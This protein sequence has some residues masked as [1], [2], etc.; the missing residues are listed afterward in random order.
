M[1]V[2]TYTETDAAT[3]EKAVQVFALPETTNSSEFKSMYGDEITQYAETAQKSI[4][5]KVKSGI[6]YYNRKYQ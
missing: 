4:I 3:G 5:Q 6:R 1:P 2:Y